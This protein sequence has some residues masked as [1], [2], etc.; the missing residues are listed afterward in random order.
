MHD[1][2]NKSAFS[3]ANRAISHGCVRVEKPLQFA[4]TLVKDKYEYDQLRM[5]VNL[6]PIDT[7]KME[8]YRKKWPKRPI[9]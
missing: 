4:E 5:E 8:I 1:T 3:R 7:T 9:R 6:P 2:N